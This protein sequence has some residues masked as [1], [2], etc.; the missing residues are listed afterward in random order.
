MRVS[1]KVL[2]EA[3]ISGK[4]SIELLPMVNTNPIDID[5]SYIYTTLT[6][7]IS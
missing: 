6:F 4:S 3:Q 1:S 5:E 7:M 2:P